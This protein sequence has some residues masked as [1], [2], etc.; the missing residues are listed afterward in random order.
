MALHSVVAPKLARVHCTLTIKVIIIPK[1]LTQ[2]REKKGGGGAE[3]WE[4]KVAKGERG[5]MG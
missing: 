5:R 1:H 4:E 2:K 3:A